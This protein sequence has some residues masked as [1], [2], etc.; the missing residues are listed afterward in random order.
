MIRHELKLTEEQEVAVVSYYFVAEQ[1]CF[2]MSTL[3][4]LKTGRAS[5]SKLLKCV[6]KLHEAH[7]DEKLNNIEPALRKRNNGYTM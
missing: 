6:M 3:S 2:L 7:I 4:E 1:E 5:I